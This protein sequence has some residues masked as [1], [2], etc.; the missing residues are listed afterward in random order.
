M[1]RSG[2]CGRRSRQGGTGRVTPTLSPNRI[3]GWDRTT[4]ILCG[5][6]EPCISVIGRDFSPDRCLAYRFPRGIW[7]HGRMGRCNSRGLGCRHFVV[8]LRCAERV[9]PS[10]TPGPTD[11]Q[12]R[13]VWGSNGRL[14][15]C[16]RPGLGAWIL[17][18]GDCTSR[19]CPCDRRPLICADQQGYH[20]TVAS[21]IPITNCTTNPLSAQCCRRC[22]AR[23]KSALRP[24]GACRFRPCP[25]IRPRCRERQLTVSLRRLGHVHWFHLSGN[26]DLC[27]KKSNVQSQSRQEPLKQPDDG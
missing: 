17:G 25:A 6:H 26:D 19:Y 16:F 15:V 22:D 11:I 21:L 20:N 8:S 9:Q 2:W 5:R 4:E 24:F 3:P 14:V 27:S 7:W 12:S 13:R 23:R 18:G 1:G 10:G